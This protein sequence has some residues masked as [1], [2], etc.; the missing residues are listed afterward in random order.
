LNV[1]RFCRTG[2]DWTEIVNIRMDI[3]RKI[4]ALI[5]EDFI[6]KCEIKKK[7]GSIDKML[8]KKLRY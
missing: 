6:Y 8:F 3:A 4:V 1:Q 7:T 2:F 5:I